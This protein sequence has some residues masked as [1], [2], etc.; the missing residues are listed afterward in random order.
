[1]SK[2]KI[3]EKKNISMNEERKHYLILSFIL[4]INS[5]LLLFKFLPSIIFW[6]TLSDTLLFDILGLIWPLIG[7]QCAIEFLFED[8]WGWGG[9][10]FHFFI[11]YCAIYYL[12]LIIISSFSFLFQIEFIFSF[13]INL[14][15]TILGWFGFFYYYD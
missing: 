10:L 5:L 9:I 11:L 2:D 8:K 4:L 3:W 15:I 7:I 14:A 13:S 6:N 1:M 12:I